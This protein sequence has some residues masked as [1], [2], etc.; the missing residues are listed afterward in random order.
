M[1]EELRPETPYSL[2]SREDWIGCCAKGAR[3]RVWLCSDNR[4]A[5]QYAPVGRGHF[6]APRMTGKPSG[7]DAAPS[8]ALGRRC[9]VTGAS[10]IIVSSPEGLPTLCKHWARAIRRFPGRDTRIAASRCSF[11]CAGSLSP[12]PQQGTQPVKPAV[13]TLA[14]A[15][16]HSQTFGDRRIAALAAAIVPGVTA[17]CFRT[18]VASVVMSRRMRRL[19][20]FWHGSSHPHAARS[21]KSKNHSAPRRGPSGLPTPGS[22]RIE[23]LEGTKRPDDTATDRVAP[24]GRSGVCRAGG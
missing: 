4:A 3:R 2:L 24:R 7:G 13:R 16:D 6:S 22:D 19:S 15:F 1:G 17:D 11:A 18:A 14:L 9:N 21:H 12:A 5:R 8:G 23:K 10:R 20:R